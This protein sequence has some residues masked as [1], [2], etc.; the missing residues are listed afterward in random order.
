MKRGFDPVDLAVPCGEFLEAVVPGLDRS[1]CAK[2]AKIDQWVAEN[3]PSCE[4][5]HD[6]AAL[7]GMFVVTGSSLSAPVS[8]PGIVIG[9][10]VTTGATLSKHYYCT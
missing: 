7:L 2:V 6:Y 5:F 3:S 1:A 9:M 10:V 8:F 4:A